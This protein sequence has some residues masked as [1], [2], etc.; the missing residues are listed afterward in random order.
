MRVPASL[1]RADPIPYRALALGAV[2]MAACIPVNAFDSA[3]VT[4]PFRLLTGLPCPA[5]GLT[6]SCIAAFHLDF[7][8]SLSLHPLGPAVAVAVVMLAVGVDKRIPWIGRTLRNPPVAIA[9]IA[10]WIAV[11]VVR[12]VQS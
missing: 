12:L 3:P 1:A 2:L 10:L 7:D 9:L 11:W 5:C 8:R 6:R 4:C